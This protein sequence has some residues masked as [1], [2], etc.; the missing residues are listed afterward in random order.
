M[1]Y[2][3]LRCEDSFSTSDTSGSQILI[4]HHCDPKREPE[5]EE[6]AFKGLKLGK[7]YQI[8]PSEACKRKIEL[9]HGC[10]FIRCH[11]RATFCFICGQ[12]VRDGFGHWNSKGGC[13]RFGQP[14][15]DRAIYDD[16]DHYDDNDEVP[17]DQQARALFY[18]EAMMLPDWQRDAQRAMEMQ[19]QYVRQ[20]QAA[21]RAEEVR[22]HQRAMMEER[23]PPRDPR[24]FGRVARG[25]RQPPEEQG[26]RRPGE[27]HSRLA[28]RQGKRLQAPKAILDSPM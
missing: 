11:C 8:C 15:D 18:R 24:R 4:E 23:S 14:G 9:S 28:Q 12:L 22:R 1:W 20:A 3:C 21:V 5:I 10:N 27:P 17:D 26:Q 25:L 16:E 2:T 7:D 6:R 13:P 19:M